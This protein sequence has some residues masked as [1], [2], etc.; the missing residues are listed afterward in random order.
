[1]RVRRRI[2]DVI[3]PDEEGN[4]LSHLFDCTIT[5][6]IFLSVVIVFAATFDLPERVAVVLRKV[7]CF[8]SIVFT[9][10][11]LLRLLTADFLFEKSGVLKARLKYVCSPMAIVDLVAIL[12]FWM[13]MFFPE[14]V[15]GVRALRLVRLL[16][17]LKLNRYFNAMQKIGDVIVSKKKE[18]LGSLFFV[19]ILMMLASLLMYSV[20]HDAQPEVFKNAFSGLWWAV[21][22]LTTVGYGDIYPI[23]ILGRVLGACIAFS[24][25]A[26]LAIPTGI[27][28]SG[29][30]ERLAHDKMV[31]EELSRQR[32]KDNEHDE[33]LRQQG[34]L[35][36]AIAEKLSVSTDWGSRKGIEE[37][38]PA[39]TGLP[40]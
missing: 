19:G 28:T 15:L 35:L 40:H 2:Y 33:L 36:M 12:P 30:T 25:I 13:P 8:A 38:Q 18:L 10:E 20:E 27:I 37:D 7:E 4:W 21:A 6:L 5:M 11:Y 39:D 26:V 34:K 1:M 24:G 16:R 31:D 22:T 9:I 14:T 29:L 32:G 17:I 3:Q 23:T